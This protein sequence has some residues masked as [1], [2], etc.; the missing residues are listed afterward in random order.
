MP[1]PEPFTP[2]D[3]IEVYEYARFLAVHVLPALRKWA[4]ASLESP[5]GTRRVA[6]ILR[7]RR[8]EAKAVSRAVPAVLAFVRSER[9]RQTTDVDGRLQPSFIEGVVTQVVELT[10]H[11]AARALVRGSTPS[12]RALT[13]F[14]GCVTALAPRRERIPPAHLAIGLR[15][16]RDHAWQRAVFHSHWFDWCRNVKRK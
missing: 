5:R 16:E 10:A 15:L 6:A 3:Y 14:A 13:D 1:L 8:D 4:D 2:D 11:P 9:G 12:Q 7:R